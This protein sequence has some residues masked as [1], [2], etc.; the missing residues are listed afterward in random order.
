MPYGHCEYYY[1]DK[2]YFLPFERI[3]IRSNNTSL[4]PKTPE[5]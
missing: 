2:N 5:E 4:D 3:R 1:S